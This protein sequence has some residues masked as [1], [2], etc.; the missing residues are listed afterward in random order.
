M[1]YTRLPR[2]T[3][4]G[5][6]YISQL[7][8]LYRRRSGSPWRMTMISALGEYRQ[9]KRGESE[10]RGIRGSEEPIYSLPKAQIIDS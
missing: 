7:V 9:P 1:N 4:G 3:T 8:N 5:D 2:H 10:M 6:Q